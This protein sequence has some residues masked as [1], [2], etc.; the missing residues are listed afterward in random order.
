MKT[1]YVFL[2]RSVTIT[3]RF[4]YMITKDR[5]TH[6]SIAFDDQLSILYSSGRKNG[7]TPFPAGPCY[8]GLNKGIFKR[9]PCIRCAVY[10][11]QVSDEVYERAKGEAQRILDNADDYKFN[12]WGMAACYMKKPYRPK[13]RFFCSQFV[14]EILT[15]SGA[16]KLPKDPSLMR[17]IEYSRLPELTCVYEGRICDLLSSG[18]PVAS[19]DDL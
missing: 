19:A 12:V 4:V 1:I 9:S 13:N 8:E 15:R 11:L 2:T 3:S 6:T 18:L 14:G 7:V 5:Y 10:A 17:P 16:V